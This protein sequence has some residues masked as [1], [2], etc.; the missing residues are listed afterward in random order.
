MIFSCE[1]V[2]V[3]KKIVYLIDLL[4]LFLYNWYSGDRMKNIR[5]WIE[6]MMFFL[7]LVVLLM[8]VK[9]EAKTLQDLYD[10]LEELESEQAKA[11]SSKKLTETEISTLEKEIASIN[12]SISEIET[13]IR[14]AEN[15]ISESEKK[16]K[17]KKE[18]TAKLLKFMQLSDDGNAYLEYIF[19]SDNYTDLM[20]RYAIVEQLSEY[21]D[22]IMKE[23]NALIEELE[24]NKVQLASKQKELSSQKE[25]MSGKLVTLNANLTELTS[26]GTTIAEDIEDI[27]KEI[28]YYKGLRCS[29]NQDITTCN[30][31]A[32][33][34]NATGWTY[35][36]VQGCV[37]SEYVGYG[38]R[39]DWSGPASGHHGI[40]L[41][42]IAEGTSVYPA[43]AGTVARVVYGSSCG[44]NMVWVYHTV[45]GKAYTTVYMHLL[46]ANVSMG[47]VVGTSTVIGRVGGGSTATVNGGYDR[48]TTGTHLHFGLA[49]GHNAYNFNAYSFNPRNLF[50]FPGT[51]SGYFSR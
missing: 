10:Q 24:A 25:K 23:L 20:Y 37:S 39:E 7:C 47:Q 18:E 19:E 43:A 31:T 8:P 12:V 2:D 11:N 28:N 6:S 45:N 36:L 32:S 15:S 30:T 48:C 21:N 44:G 34:P 9:I 46:S 49:Y 40:D 13:D 17:E 51:Y 50:S 38:Q 1:K 22:G 14:K 5:I 35:P 33:A 41:A 26:E 16:I 3:W 4:N 42:C 29:K 27:K